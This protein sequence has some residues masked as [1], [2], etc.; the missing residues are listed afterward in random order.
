MARATVTVNQ[1][2]FYKW[3]IF[4]PGCECAHGMNKGWSFNGDYDRPT[5]K[6]SILVRGQH[7]TRPDG[8]G[9]EDDGTL[10]KT[11]C[12]SFVTDGRIQFLGDCTHDLKGQT[13]D[14]PDEF[15]NDFDTADY[16]EQAEA[17]LN[18]VK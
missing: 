6:P 5:F 3:I 16:T 4:C 10:V 11:V 12:H 8:T 14:L 13:V 2:K 17:L 18:R 9:S 15:N 7:G 1:G